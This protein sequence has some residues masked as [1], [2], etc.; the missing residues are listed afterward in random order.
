MK[1]FSGEVV[2]THQLDF[3]SEFIKT[4]S[5]NCPIDSVMIYQKNSEVYFN[6]NYILLRRYGKTEFIKAI[7]TG[8]INLWSVNI[9]THSTTND[10][11]QMSSTTEYLVYSKDLYSPM[12]Q[13]RYKHLKH[14]L[15][16]NPECLKKL[17]KMRKFWTTEAKQNAEIKKIVFLYNKI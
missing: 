13:A 14:A 5:R 8:K 12:K 11:Y 10:G 16:D 4:D 15:S 9:T 2:K 7:T 17:K 6:P 1:L 3:T